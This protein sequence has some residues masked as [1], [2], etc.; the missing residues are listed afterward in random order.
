MSGRDQSLLSGC[1][2]K[3]PE[4]H[5]DKGSGCVDDDDDDWPSSLILLMADDS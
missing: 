1:L 3:G 5:V 4:D 2:D